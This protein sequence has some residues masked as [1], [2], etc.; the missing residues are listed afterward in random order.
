MYVTDCAD[1][2]II[3]GGTP[4]SPSWNQALASCIVALKRAR[5]ISQ[6]TSKQCNHRRGR[7][8]AVAAG[9]A[10]GPAATERGHTRERLRR[11]RRIRN[12]RSMLGRGLALA[13]VI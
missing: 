7:F 1:R 4:R 6:F 2:V 10:Y 9:F 13:V 3:G 11:I 5:E 8:P 12:T